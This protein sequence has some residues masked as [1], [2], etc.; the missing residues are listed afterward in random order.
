MA[1]VIVGERENLEHALKRFKKKVE[2]EGIIKEYKDRRY[3][4]KPSIIKREKRKESIR[5]GQVKAR[6]DAKRRDRGR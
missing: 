6:Q 2:D 3:F 5:K 1:H 4:K